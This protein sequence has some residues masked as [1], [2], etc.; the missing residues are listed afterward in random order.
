MDYEIETRCLHLE[1]DRAENRFGAISFPIYQT[2]TFAHKGVGE[3]T[4]YDYT[5]LQNPTREQ[6]EKVVA[7]LEKG[8]DA[9]AFSSGMAA[10]GAVME[11]FQPG[12]HLITDADLYGG[13][14]R[15]FHNISEKNGISITSVD[16]SRDNV[17][18]YITEKTKA[19]YIETPTNPM[20]NVTDIR[21]LS[22]LIGEKGI[23][24][25]VDNTFLSPYLQN[26][27]ELGADIVI[28]SGTKYLGGHNDTIAG[29]LVT[30]DREISERLRFIIKTT[31]AGL[32]PFDSWLIMRGIQTLAVRMDR[33]Q[34]N[35]AALAEWLQQQKR[36]TRVIYPGL[37]S[38]PGYEIMKKQSRGFGAMITF[39]VEDKEL[40]LSL[41][42]NVRLIRF[43]ESLGG[44]ETLLT[45]P[46]TQTHA[47]VPAEE[48]AKNGISDRTLRLSVGIE[49]IG[50]L[51]SEFERIFRLGEE[52]RN[53]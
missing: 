3:S 11:L 37:P 39:D 31:G 33:A 17:S 7:S 23:L 44:T 22:R 47:D 51:I 18:R 28:H 35:A 9:L 36:V 19:V 8:V 38:H 32:S 2:A 10:I 27:L 40:A 25:I 45:Y 52:E 48:L 43:A 34:E 46:I 4:G 21:K 42:R 29:F 15:L 1:G 14:V 6:L 20:V 5:R 26:P 13:S 49:S 41:L 24:L 50:D 53:E 16:C 30:N 12:D